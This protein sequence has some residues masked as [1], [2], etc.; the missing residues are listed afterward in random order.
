MTCNIPAHEHT[1]REHRPNSRNCTDLQAGNPQSLTVQPRIRIHRAVGQGGKN[2]KEDVEIVQQRLKDLGM[3]WVTVD[4]QSG[5]QTVKTIQLFQAMYNS[6]NVA[7]MDGKVDPGGITEQWLFAKNAPRWVKLTSNA[8]GGYIIKP[9]NEKWCSSWTRDVI[10]A[11]GRAFKAKVKANLKG[12]DGKTPAQAVLDEWVIVITAL[13][14][15]KGGDTTSHKSH[16]AGMDVDVRLFTA[17]GPTPGLTISSS[18][19][20]STWTAHAIAAFMAQRLV[21]NVFF[22]DGEII[23]DYKDETVKVKALGGHS[24][25]FHVDVK[26]PTR[27]ELIPR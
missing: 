6:A 7:G 23:D 19:Y 27:G 13:S 21:S 11:A 17:K 4:G 22:N 26:A 12:A 9:T 14:L 8:A 18:S 2:L 3:D 5:P 15:S 24:N 1:P 25:H 10:I 16:E 20:S